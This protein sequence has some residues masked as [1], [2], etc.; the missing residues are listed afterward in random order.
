MAEMS[1][2]PQALLLALLALQL[3]PLVTNVLSGH[4]F[5][6]GEQQ[7]NNPVNERL[8]RH[9]TVEGNSDRHKHSGSNRETD[10][11]TIKVNYR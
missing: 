5:W 6:V 4:T 7:P 3:A 10:I 11:T 9:Q 2:S 1:G 8:S